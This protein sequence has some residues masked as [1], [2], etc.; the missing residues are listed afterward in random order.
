MHRLRRGER[1][2]QSNL[3]RTSCSAETIPAFFR[4][5]EEE[6][7][8]FLRHPRGGTGDHFTVQGTWVSFV[9]SAVVSL[10]IPQAC[11]DKGYANM[12]LQYP[13][14]GIVQEFNF[15][16]WSACSSP[17]FEW[18]FELKSFSCSFP[19][20]IQV[21]WV[22]GFRDAM[23]PNLRVL[24]QLQGFSEAFGPGPRFQY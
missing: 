3:C 2:K 22:G 24:G 9:M 13:G 1:Q 7:E 16:V 14:C 5:C 6:E 23:R 8:R 20:K 10:R 11:T 17:E 19:S 21:G 12:S 15:C 18:N 4:A